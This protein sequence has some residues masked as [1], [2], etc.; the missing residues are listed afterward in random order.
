MR[1][2]GKGIADRWT[3]VQPGDTVGAILARNRG[4]GPSFDHLRLLLA[5]LIL[6]GH[7]HWL[8]MAPSINS[9][10]ENFHTASRLATA[11]VAATYFVG[12]VKAIDRALVPSFFAVSGFLV[13]GSALRLRATSTF[14]AHRAL[15]I[16]PALLVEVTLSALIL[17]PLLTKLPLHDYFINPELARYFGN[18]FGQI[19]F[20]LPGVFEDNPVSRIVN[21]NLWTLPAE[22]HCYLITAGLLLTKIIY[23]KLLFGIVF[24]FGTI[25]L[26][27]IN[28]FTDISSADIFFPSHVMVYYFF[29]GCLFYHF[30]EKIPAHFVLFA[31]ALMVAFGALTYKPLAYV[32]P[33][34]LTY[35]TVF[36]GLVRLPKIKLIDSGDYS[37]GIYLYGFPIIQTYVSLFPDLRGQFML[38]T[39]LAGGTTFLFAAFS[40]HVI[41]KRVLALKANLPQRWF[42]VIRAQ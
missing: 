37:Y 28:F 15:R 20:V 42:P 17:G 19:S 3:G 33:I 13:L 30:K 41:E 26:A 12:V 11:G 14:L 6:I 22:F 32:A 29:C 9:L 35:C 16:F 21:L 36:F 31:G 4:V 38:L 2:G 23:N 7:A 5:T 39:G 8:S 10:F 25:S 24:V 18:L 1:R 34:P 40:W 27:L